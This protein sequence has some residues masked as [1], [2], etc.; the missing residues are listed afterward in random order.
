[1]THTVTAMASND[2]V[3]T[4]DR[5]TIS[6]EHTGPLLQIFAWLF[7]TFSI[8]CVVAQFATKRALSRRLEVSDHLLLVALVMT[9]SSKYI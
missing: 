6:E 1:M 9:L 2:V 8:L 5:P 4:R 7:L 3:F